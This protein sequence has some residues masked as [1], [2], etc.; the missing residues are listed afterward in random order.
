M[1]RVNVL[2]E[3]SSWSK[4]IK[5]KGILFNK[6]SKN[7]P[8]KYKFNKK[9]AHL[10]LLLSNNKQIKILN[11]KFRRKN[12][13]TDVLSFPFEQKIKNKKEIYL[14]DIIISYNYMNKPKNITNIDFTKKTVKIFIHGFLHLMGY[15]HIKDR[16]FEKM[17]KA[18]KKIFSK[19]EKLLN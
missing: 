7:F 14:G 15:D 5:K 1:I 12:K 13:H 18:E 6:I 3:E 19:I 9:I 11:K 4:K 2:T 17:Q 10:T 16:D 8:D